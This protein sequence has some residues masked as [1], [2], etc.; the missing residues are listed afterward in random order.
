MNVFL[1]IHCANLLRLPAH[2]PVPD[3]LRFV[4]HCYVYVLKA[5]QSNYLLGLLL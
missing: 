5:M 3:M 1:C 2:L 4:Q